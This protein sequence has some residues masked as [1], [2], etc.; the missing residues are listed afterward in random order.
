LDLKYEADPEEPGLYWATREVPLKK[1]FLYRPD[2]IYDNMDV[3]LDGRPLDRENI[4]TQF[5]CPELFAPN[6]IIGLT[7]ALVYADI[8][9]IDND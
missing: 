3:D 9:L 8:G 6:S 1:V 7:I 2:S 4:C 5:G